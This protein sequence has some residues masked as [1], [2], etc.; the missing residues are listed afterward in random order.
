MLERVARHADSQFGRDHRFAQ[1]RTTADFRRQVPIRGYEGHEP[2][3]ERVRNGD[4]NA[5]FGPGTE[6]L[7]FAMTSGTT[8]RPKTIP[9]TRQSLQDYREGWTIWGIRAFDTHF[10]GLR[11][12]LR[13]ILQLASDW[14]RASPRPGY[15]AGRSRG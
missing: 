14:R 11:R 8:N 7:M 15:L 12:G 3:I 5:L 2:Y 1:I 4:V 10:D 9:V 13:P 6:V